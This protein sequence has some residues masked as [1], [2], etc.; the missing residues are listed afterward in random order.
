M[1]RGQDA[2][3]SQKKKQE[4]FKVKLPSVEW[5]TIDIYYMNH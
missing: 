4:L 1:R 2:A 5:W 3:Q